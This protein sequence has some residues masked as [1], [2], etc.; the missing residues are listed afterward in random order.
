MFI[1]H[2]ISFLYIVVPPQNWFYKGY[3]VNLRSIESI[4]SKVQHKTSGS[5]SWQ[6][7]SR[8]EL[9]VRRASIPDRVTDCRVQVTKGICNATTLNGIQPS[10]VKSVKNETLLSSQLEINEL[11]EALYN[12]HKLFTTTVRTFASMNVF[13]A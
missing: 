6:Q 8:Y 11:E 10:F 9:A 12:E 7:S 1:H 4:S 5:S 3:R 13:N 2:H